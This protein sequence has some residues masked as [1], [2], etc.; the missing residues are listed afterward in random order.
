MGVGGRYTLRRIGGACLNVFRMR[1]IPRYLLSHSINVLRQ[2]TGVERGTSIK[3]SFKTVGSAVVLFHLNG[4]PS[5]EEQK[6]VVTVS[7]QLLNKSQPV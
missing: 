2:L 4:T 1:K 7:K 6:A 5:R 3:L